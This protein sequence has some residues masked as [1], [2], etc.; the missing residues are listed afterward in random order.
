MCEGRQGPVKEPPLRS[1]HRPGRYSAR[2]N[3]AFN[4]AASDA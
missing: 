3:S 1:V 4:V 2:S